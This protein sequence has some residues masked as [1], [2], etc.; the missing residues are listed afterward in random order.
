V[1]VFELTI[2][3]LAL[4]APVGI[5]HVTTHPAE[6]VVPAVANGTLNVVL[7]PMYLL[8]FVYAYFREPRPAHSEPHIL[9]ETLRSGASQHLDYTEMRDFRETLARYKA[10]C[11]AA[12]TPVGTSAIDAIAAIG[13]IRN[14]PAASAVARRRNRERLL[15][16]RSEA[17]ADLLSLVC[18]IPNATET[19]QSLAASLDDH[20]DITLQ[21]GL[22][23]DHQKTSQNSGT[24]SMAA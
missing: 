13:L 17:R 24:V 20:A 21:P 18:N 8:S 23:S 14:A 12:E 15:R 19:I 10:L 16:Q 9:I 2:I 4:G 6:A 5:Y 3:Y 11:E 22:T 7:W 1:N